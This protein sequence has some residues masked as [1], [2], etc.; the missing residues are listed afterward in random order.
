MCLWFG[1]LCV[2]FDEQRLNLCLLSI[3]KVYMDIIH[4]SLVQPKYYNAELLIQ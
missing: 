1:W 4:R 2:L 3:V